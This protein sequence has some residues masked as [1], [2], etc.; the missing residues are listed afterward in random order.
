MATINPIVSTSKKCINSSDIYMVN[1]SEFVQIDKC[2]LLMYYQTDKGM[3]C[4][5]CLD[6]NIFR[7]AS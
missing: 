1:G 5:A 7:P 3:L 6:Q 4:S 2:D